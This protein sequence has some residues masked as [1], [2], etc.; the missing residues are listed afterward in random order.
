MPVSSGHG[1]I[2][3]IH[4]DVSKATGLARLGARLG[5]DPADMLAFGDGGNDL[6]MLEFVGTGV[7]MANAPDNVK[8]AADAMTGSNDD[9]G[10]LTYL[11]GVFAAPTADPYGPTVP[12]PMT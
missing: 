3:L 10:V 8:Q 9:A 7:A 5:I 4:R 6:S 12:A 1:S 11:E 2:D